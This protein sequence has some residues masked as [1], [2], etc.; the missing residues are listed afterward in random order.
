VGRTIVSD[1]SVG[2]KAAIAF[3][4]VLCL[5]VHMTIWQGDA[6]TM[7]VLTH[8]CFIDINALSKRDPF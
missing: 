2:T 8:T 7:G 3:T 1:A 6:G 5:Y 4:V